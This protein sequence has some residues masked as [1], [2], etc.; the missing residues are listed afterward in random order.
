MN[1][2]IRARYAAAE[3][4]AAR[5]DGDVEKAYSLIRRIARYALADAR[6][7]ERDNTEGLYNEQ[8][9]IHAERLLNA[10]RA[11]LDYELSTNYGV[12][13]V[14]YGLYPSIEECGNEGRE[15]C[16]VAYYD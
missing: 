16:S 5:G 14:N 4:L 9:S 13:L 10:R 15:V 8:Q 1:E 7:W 12:R 2:I 3:T 6:Q 11:N